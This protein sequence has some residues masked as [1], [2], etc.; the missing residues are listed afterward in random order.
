M[1]KNDHQMVERLEDQLNALTE[2][3]KTL[4]LTFE[5]PEL[6]DLVLRKIV[7]VLQPAHAGVVMLW[8]QPSGLFRPAAIVG[9][10]AATF[11]RIGLRAGES[12]TG[13]VYDSGKATLLNTPE[14]VAQA[15]EDMRPANRAV[16]F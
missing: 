14:L 6:L 7:S 1:G 4:T 15:M 13:K 2:V 9:F 3:S 16:F 12:I 11:V 5:L 8:D 10:D